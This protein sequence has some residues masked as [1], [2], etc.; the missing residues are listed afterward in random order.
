MP[1][2][3][4]QVCAEDDCGDVPGRIILPGQPGIEDTLDGGY[5]PEIVDAIRARTRGWVLDD[6]GQFSAGLIDE[7]YANDQ[8]PVGVKAWIRPWN[9][10]SFGRVI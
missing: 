6:D 4:P 10:D 5:P 7:H 8:F 1:A 3:L 2:M 9:L